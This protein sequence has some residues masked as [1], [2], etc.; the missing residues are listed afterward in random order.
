MRVVLIKD[1]MSQ[2]SQTRGVKMCSHV[3]NFLNS[4]L[5]PSVTSDPQHIGGVRREFIFYGLEMGL[6]KA[7]LNQAT[8][9]CTTRA[10]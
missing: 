4:F 5:T 7:V 2:N 10:E 3:R 1:Q 9:T 8:L 6:E